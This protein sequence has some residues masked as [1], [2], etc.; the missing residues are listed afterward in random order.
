LAQCANLEDP[1]LGVGVKTW[2]WRRDQLDRSQAY[3]VV[4]L[5]SRTGGRAANGNRL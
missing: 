5:K 4:D 3:Q 1:W 2:T